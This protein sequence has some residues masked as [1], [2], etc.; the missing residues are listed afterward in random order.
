MDRGSF[1]P[2]TVVKRE[3]VQVESS[4][5]SANT[6]VSEAQ[7]AST[8]NNCSNSGTSERYNF[9]SFS[10]KLMNEDMIRATQMRAAMKSMD[11]LRD[12]LEKKRRVRER[13][14]ELAAAKAAEKD[15]ASP[16][17]SPA[18]NTHSRSWKTTSTRDSR[19]MKRPK[20][21]RRR[22]RSDPEDINSF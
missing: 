8:M 14:A 3:K 16:G 17:K 6:R 12:I 11:K 1:Q 15:A 20:P 18:T 22:R 21:R 10:Q 9:T 2:F 4:G 5:P 13:A 7:P 19:R